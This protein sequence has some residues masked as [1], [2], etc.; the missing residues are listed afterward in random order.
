MFEIHIILFYLLI[1][2]F[3]DWRKG[4][5]VCIMV[6]FAQDPIRKFMP[7]QSAYYSTMIVLYIMATLISLIHKNNS[8]RWNLL[9]QM[10]P[11]LKMP[12]KIFFWIVI[13]QACRAL[14]LTNSFAIMGIGIVGYIGPLLGIFLAFNFVLERGDLFQLVKFYMIVGIIFVSFVLAEAMGFQWTI[15]GSVGGEHIFFYTT[16]KLVLYSGILRAAEISAWHGT[17]IAMLGIVIFV[18]SRHSWKRYLWLIVSGIALASILFTGRRKGFYVAGGFIVIAVAMAFLTHARSWKGYIASIVLGCVLVLITFQIVSFERQ[19][20]NFESYYDRLIG[21]FSNETLIDRITEMTIKSFKW[22]ILK[23]GI[24][25]SGAGTGSQGAQ[26]FGG[27][28]TGG[29]TEGGL[30]KVLGE[31]GIPGLTVGIWLFY[32][33]LQNIWQIIG[34]VIGH[35]RNETLAIGLGAILFANAIS[36]SVA[37]QAFGDPFVMFVMGLM[38]GFLLGIPLISETGTLEAWEEYQHREVPVPI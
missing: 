34:Y 38:L 30:A 18:L 20:I 31:L 36:F 33:F 11:S 3:L 27:M 32:V 5:F 19:F 12:L 23:N 25:G 6:G 35:H 10:Y 16:H 15:L 29:A 22:V 8:L 26:H 7:G 37:K 21:R 13:F 9:L 4:L 2:C 24:I 17:L 1:V 28:R 14:L